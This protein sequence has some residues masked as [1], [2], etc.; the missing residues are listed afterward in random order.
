[1]GSLRHTDNDN[2]VRKP[3]ISY[4]IEERMI[5]EALIIVKILF[6]QSISCLLPSTTTRNKRMA[7]FDDDARRRMGVRD[8][9]NCGGC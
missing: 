1:M 4:G 2:D 9:R 5:G 3:S 8:M 6:T 7:R